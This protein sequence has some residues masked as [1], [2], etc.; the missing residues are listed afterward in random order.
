M[1][2]ITYLQICQGG[3]NRKNYLINNRRNGTWQHNM[4]ENIIQGKQHAG[5]H[6]GI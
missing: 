4:Q 6:I 3:N 1:E 5:I 2:R